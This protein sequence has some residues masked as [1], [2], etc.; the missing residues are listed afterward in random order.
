VLRDPTKTGAGVSKYFR[1]Q[2]LTP[3]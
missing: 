3:A 1:K 2:M